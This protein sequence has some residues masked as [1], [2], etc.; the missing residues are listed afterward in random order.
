MFNFRRSGGWSHQ[1]HH[2]DTGWR[3]INME[4]GL[5]EG[6][7]VTVYLRRQGSV[8]E[9][10]ATGDVGAQVTI[11]GVAPEGFRPSREVRGS[12]YNGDG[13]DLFVC[14]LLGADYPSAPV[15]GALGWVGGESAGAGYEGFGVFSV[16]FNYFTDDLW[17]DPLPGTAVEDENPGI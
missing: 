11:N 13:G 6:F 12:G 17:P 8:V 4:L 14:Q 1:R 9:L 3:Q 2:W 5:Y 7:E 16:S 15:R 10:S